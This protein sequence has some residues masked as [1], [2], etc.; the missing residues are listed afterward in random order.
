MML[1]QPLRPCC[2]T[3]H[4]TAQLFSADYLCPWHSLQQPLG[5]LVCF[6]TAAFFLDMF[7]SYSSMYVMP[8][9]CRLSIA[10]YQAGGSRLT[11]F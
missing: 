2:A 4:T 6:T 3:C 1:L 10:V 7:A 9:R 11:A 8:F 5:E